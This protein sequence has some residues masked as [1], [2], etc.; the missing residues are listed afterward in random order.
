MR[1]FLNIYVS[2]IK[3]FYTWAFVL[4]DTGEDSKLRYRRIFPKKETASTIAKFA[5]ERHHLST[6]SFFGTYSPARV[7]KCLKGF[8]FAEFGH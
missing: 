6:V 4:T 1:F 3:T 7:N 2:T 5:L 8:E